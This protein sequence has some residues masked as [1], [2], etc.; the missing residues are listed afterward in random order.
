[1]FLTGPE[2]IKAVTGEV[3]DAESLGGTDVHMSITGTAHLACATEQEALEL[4]R[5]VI[6]YFPANNVENP[7][8]YEPDDDPLRMDEAL[9]S[10]VPLDPTQPYSMHT[11]IEKIVDR[12]TFVEIQPAWAQNAIVGLA[13]IGGHSVGIVAQ[14]PM[15]LAGVIDID[16]A[17]KMAR[18]VRMCDCFNIP[19]VTF[20]DSPGFLPGI[21]A[22]ARRHHPAWREAALCLLRSHRP[23]GHR[24]HPQGLRRRVCG[25][26][27]QI[28]RNRCYLCLA[29]R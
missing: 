17:D 2:V 13:R 4:A 29:E 22:R 24:D 21:A 12:G 20:V 16:A 6:G 23:E 18:F 28:P 8:Y 11:V 3:I 10:I 15:C 27:Q 1:M 25:D 7:P 5:R 26:E 9:N 14:E 19:L